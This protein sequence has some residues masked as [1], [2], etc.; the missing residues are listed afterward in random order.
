MA[1]FIDML[2]WNWGNLD[3]EAQRTNDYWEKEKWSLL[4]MGHLLVVEF[5]V[6]SLETTHYTCS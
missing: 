3:K 6:V 1:I 2:M 4:G 5:R